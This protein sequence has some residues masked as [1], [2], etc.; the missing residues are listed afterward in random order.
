MKH[1][2]RWQVAVELSEQMARTYPEELL[3][4]G[5][6]GSTARGSDTEWSDLEMLF[7]VEDRCEAK[8]K[9]VLFRGITLG[10]RVYRRSELESILR[11]PSLKW[12]FH[13][14]AL[15]VLKVLYGDVKL[16]DEWLALGQAAPNKEFRSVLLE[17]LP[18]L[19][20]ESYG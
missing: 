7:V 8:G 19:V 2:E 15:S 20:N 6:Y 3:L 13:M 5:V 11:H 14:G 1:E 18:G 10:Y 17:L 12:P 9:H 4:G 16:I